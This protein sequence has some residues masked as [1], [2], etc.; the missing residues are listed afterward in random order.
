VDQAVLGAH[1]DHIP[2]CPDHTDAWLETGEAYLDHSIG[3]TAGVCRIG[4]FDVI[5]LDLLQPAGVQERIESWANVASPNSV[6]TCGLS[7]AKPA[8]PVFARGQV[9]DLDAAIPSLEGGE[10]IGPKTLPREFVTVEF[11]FRSN[12]EDWT[13]GR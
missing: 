2:G 6:P 13:I 3:L 7:E 8:E 12:R 4:I 9:A 1:R 11:L 10:R 5:D